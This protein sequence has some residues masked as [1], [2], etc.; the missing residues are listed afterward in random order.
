MFVTCPA[1]IGIRVHDP[2]RKSNVSNALLSGHY[3]D[4]LSTA[5]QLPTL[6]HAG[7]L[8]HFVLRAAPTE[9]RLVAPDVWK[10]L[11]TGFVVLTL[12]TAR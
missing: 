9:Q 11:P 12:K 2:C 10:D 4:S 3:S 1:P 5:S 7:Q 6:Q 8:D